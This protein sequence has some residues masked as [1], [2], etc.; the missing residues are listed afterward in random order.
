MLKERLEKLFPNNELVLEIS[1]I[2]DDAIMRRMIERC[3]SECPIY[4]RKIAVETGTYHG[5]SAALLAEYFDEVH[6]F[7]IKTGYF[8]DSKLPGRV[9]EALGVSD[10][11]HPYIVEK[12]SEKTAIVEGLDYDF[13]FIDGNHNTGLDYDY[14]MLKSCGRVLFHDYCPG[15]P[16]ENLRTYVVNFVNALEPAAITD[17]PFALWV[18]QPRQLL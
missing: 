18:K 11:I 6:T 9:W 5:V 13:A 15:F 1:A 16:P 7:D 4:G 10:K 2:G 8:V 12:D 3:L 17:P 14:D